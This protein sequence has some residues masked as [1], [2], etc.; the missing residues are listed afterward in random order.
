MKIDLTSELAKLLIHTG[1]LA[2]AIRHYSAYTMSRFQHPDAPY[3]IM[4]LSDSL[5]NFNSLGATILEGEPQRILAACDAHLAMHCGPV[6]QSRCATA[7]ANARVSFE[8]TARHNADSVRDILND[9]RAK[10]LSVVTK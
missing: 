9:I 3:H 1:N 4:W 7:E 2:T 8:S 5:H 6:E 10:A